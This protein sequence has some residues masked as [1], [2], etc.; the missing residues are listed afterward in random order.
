MQKP[1]CDHR[2]PPMTTVTEH[3]TTTLMSFVVVPTGKTEEWVGT[4]GV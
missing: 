1:I 2:G 4:V 3:E